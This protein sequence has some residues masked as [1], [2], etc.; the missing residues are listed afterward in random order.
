MR[1]SDSLLVHFDTKKPLVLAEDASPYGISTILS[2]VREN[3]EERPIAFAL[4]TLN[5][6]EDKYA[7]I[8]REGL[9]QIF[10]VKKFRQYLSWM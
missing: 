6:T 4:R 1:A 10:G 7:H 3:G 8:D 5:K 9:T 2:H